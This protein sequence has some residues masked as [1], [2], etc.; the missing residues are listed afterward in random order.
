M[1]AIIHPT[2]PTDLLTTSRTCMTHDVAVTAWWSTCSAF[3][4]KRNGEP[5]SEKMLHNITA[6]LKLSLDTECLWRRKFCRL[7]KR[8]PTGGS[9]TRDIQHITQLAHILCAWESRHGPDSQRLRQLAAGQRKTRC[10][11]GTPS[12]A[13][14][15]RARGAWGAAGGAGTRCGR[16]AGT[17]RSNGSR[18][19]RRRLQAIA[20]LRG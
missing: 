6:Q 9:R 18:S 15:T 12:P 3:E 14:R 17:R 19:Q 1:F 20:V 10:T 13:R 8:P 5:N 16:I 4:G 2:C 11:S 7:S